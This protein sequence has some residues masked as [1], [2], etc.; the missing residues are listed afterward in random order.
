MSHV[1]ITVTHD[2][3]S[4]LGTWVDKIEEK[5]PFWCDDCEAYPSGKWP[6]VLTTEL[7]DERAQSPDLPAG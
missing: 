7:I 1:K 5:Y 3:G 6:W 2:C 4:L